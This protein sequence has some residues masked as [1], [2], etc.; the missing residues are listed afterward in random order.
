MQGTELWSEDCFAGSLRHRE[1]RFEKPD[2]S[3]ILDKILEFW[4][5][6][7]VLSAASRPGWA[8]RFAA[9][10]VL[11]TTTIIQVEREQRH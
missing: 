11:N 10:I 7:E 9:L 4:N 2:D 6:K 3:A 8:G 1:T 5:N